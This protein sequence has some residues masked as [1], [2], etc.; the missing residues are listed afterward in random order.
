MG[1]ILGSE[2]EKNLVIS[3][4]HVG[5]SIGV[6]C[7]GHTAL[8]VLIFN[9]T[10]IEVPCSLL[11][12]LMTVT[13][14]FQIEIESNHLTSNFWWFLNFYKDIILI[15]WLNTESHN[16]SN[17]NSIYIIIYVSLLIQIMNCS[18]FIIQL[19]LVSILKFELFKRCIVHVGKLSHRQQPRAN[20]Q[21]STSI[22]YHIY[23]SHFYQY[24]LIV[25]LLCSQYGPFMVSLVNYMEIDLYYLNENI[26]DSQTISVKCVSI[27][28][29]MEKFLFCCDSC[30]IS[31]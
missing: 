30:S 14:V 4:G 27:C 1:T 22:C 8:C 10:L 13:Y 20:L 15:T 24:W 17:T 7:Q 11:L 29:G 12:I 26:S 9:G 23:T 21:H 2:S 18:F 6:V 16:N 3:L 5:I 25:P 28:S 31:D 19:S